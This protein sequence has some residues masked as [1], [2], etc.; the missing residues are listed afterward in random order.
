ME[1]RREVRTN[2]NLAI[3]LTELEAPGRIPQKAVLTNVSRSGMLVRMSHGIACGALVK[4]KA[5]GILTLGEVVRCLPADQEFDVALALRNT[6]EDLVV[7][8]Q[9]WS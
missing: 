3:E 8:I 4:V 1:H 2:V 9:S 7:L 5:K 6:L